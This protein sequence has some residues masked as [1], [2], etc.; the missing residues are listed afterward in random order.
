MIPLD[1]GNATFVTDTS[2][3][4]RQY[5]Y[6][7]PLCTRLRKDAV[8]ILSDALLRES[9]KVESVT[10]RVKSL[11]S[12]LDKMRRT[13]KTFK[14]VNDLLGLRVVCLFRSQIKA[15]AQV[16]GKD[17]QVLPDLVDNKFESKDI[18]RFGYLDLKL[19]AKLRPESVGG[20]IGLMALKDFLFEI[21]IRTVGMHAWAT[22]SHYLDYKLPTQV[23]R[24]LRRDFQAL[25]ALFH[26]A[27]SQF[28]AFFTAN[29]TRAN[30]RGE[31]LSSPDL[32]SELD[33]ES[34]F[35][36][37]Q[38]RF[39]TRISE[40]ASGT[41]SQFLLELTEAGI[42]RLNEVEVAVDRWLP[43]ILEHEKGDPPT[44]HGNLKGQFTAVG[45]A[46]IAVAS[47]FEHFAKN[48]AVVRFRV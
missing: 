3:V 26:V 1:N 13:G 29:Q 20:W 5:E 2:D 30:P 45:V 37:L 8:G 34:L 28:E 18:D 47:Q 9:I 4:Q 24:D 23:P 21:Q 15:I 19:I 25:S 32:Y 12:L 41:V 16:A 36:Y 7:M 33:L 42:Y 44:T 11:Q 39:P 38:T 43:A 46:R 31:S 40:T 6:W 22:V 27:D 17:F 10:G 48:V 35:A 14:Q